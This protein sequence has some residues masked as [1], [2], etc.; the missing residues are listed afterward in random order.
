MNRLLAKDH[1]CPVAF[2]PLLTATICI[3]GAVR[4]VSGVMVDAMTEWCSE[5]CADGRDLNTAHALP[6]TTRVQRVLGAR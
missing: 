5:N 4:T 2:Q 3:A 1:A 6:R